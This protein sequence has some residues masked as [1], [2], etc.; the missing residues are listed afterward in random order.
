MRKNIANFLY[1]GIFIISY[2]ISLLPMTFLYAIASC[3]FFLAYHVI[4]Y[5]KAVVIQNIS[6]SFPDMKY[7]E[8]RCNVKKF[9]VCFTAYFAEMLKNISIPAKVLIKKMSFLPISLF[10]NYLLVCVS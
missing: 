2:I 5:R 7:G 6:R 9:Y 1:K 4:G 3:T 10:S 8:I